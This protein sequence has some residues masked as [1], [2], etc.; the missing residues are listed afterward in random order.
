[1][2]FNLLRENLPLK[3]FSLL[4][5]IATWFVMRG[6]V[7]HVKDYVVPIDYVHLADNLEMSGDIPNTVDVRLRA[8][9]PVLKRANDYGMTAL[10]DL[11]NSPPGEHQIRL[12]ESL[13]DMPGGAQVVRISPALI[14]IRIEK[15]VT[16]EVPVVAAFAGSPA[17]GYRQV[18]QQIEPAT[19]TVSGPAS[20]VE[21]VQ[22]ALTGTIVLEGATDD[23]EVKLRPVPDAPEGSR[24]RV[25]YPRDPVRVRV[26]IEPP[27]VEIG[28][29]MNEEPFDSGPEP[30][31]G[32]AS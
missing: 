26:T 2:R 30:G 17:E 7:E 32:A 19:V 14:P 4:V 12:S 21:A 10:I 6:E 20:E 29:T 27:P 8:A 15:K 22:R 3:I 16:R 23:I 18:G 13:L 9:E 11:S 5:A 28:P 1:M 24:V 25:V 31:D